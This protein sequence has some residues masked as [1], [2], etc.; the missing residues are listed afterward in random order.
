M[1]NVMRRPFFIFTII[2]FAHRISFFF[3]RYF[4]SL[5]IILIIYSTFFTFPSAAL[6][7]SAFN[8]QN[9]DLI[10]STNTYS[11]S[12]RLLNSSNVNL[13]LNF[14]TYFG[15]YFTQVTKI[16]IDTFGNSY[17]TGTTN[18]SSFPTKN[19]YNS[20]Y[21]GGD[22]IFLAKFDSTGSLIFSTYFGGF[23]DDHASNF[24]V[25]TSGNSYISGSTESSNFPTKNGYN[26]TFGNYIIGNSLG[27]DSFLAKFN[28]NGQLISSTFLGELWVSGITSDSAGNCYITTYN[29]Y[30]EFLTKINASGGLVFRYNLDFNP[31]KIVVDSNGSGYVIGSRS[32]GQFIVKIDSS[33]HTI[34]SSN[35]GSSIHI[36]NVAVD[37]SGS[38]IY[39][40][41][42]ISSDAT[43]SD[44]YIAKLNSTGGIIFQRVMSGN[45][46]DSAPNII[47]DSTGNS[48]I[49][50]ITLSR[51]F[52][53]KN[54]FQANNKGMRDV[55]VTKFNSSGVLVF[56]TFLGGS[57]NDW[58]NSIDIDLSGNSYITGITSSSDFPTWNAFNS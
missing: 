37:K 1:F 53:I 49:S 10:H 52:P 14:S 57:A 22:D 19:A 18:S 7:S 27:S 28:T 44:V 39:V 42:S 24:F 33:N 30:G 25:D 43:G 2:K 56:S 45:E 40:T 13:N 4:K 50:G 47:V 5:F 46:T 11:F 16:A 48:Y 17:I 35:L 26:S 29:M 54:P 38:F 20:T 34:F 8:E 58:F 36:T 55:F 32:S 12:T 9:F 3:Q 41:G 6:S 15:N 31:V 23:R 51:D 21:S